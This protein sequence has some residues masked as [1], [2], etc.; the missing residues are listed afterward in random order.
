M[1]YAGTITVSKVYL[2][3]HSN[4]QNKVWVSK[5]KIIVIN[6]TTITYP[7]IAVEIMK[8]GKFA[9]SFTST[10]SRMKPLYDPCLPNKIFSL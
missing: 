3:Y 2:Y 6:P 8:P 10:S 4:N 1:I 9:E 5:V 7:A